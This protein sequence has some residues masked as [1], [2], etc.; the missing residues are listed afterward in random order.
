MSAS[1]SLYAAMP[2]LLS[3]RLR[4]SIPGAMHMPDLIAILSYALVA[5][6]LAYFALEFLFTGLRD[7]MYKAILR[8]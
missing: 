8:H 6:A 5:V 3:F 2:E 4:N 7:R 1:R